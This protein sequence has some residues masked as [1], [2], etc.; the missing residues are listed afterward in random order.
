MGRSATAAIAVVAVVIFGV[1]I[2]AVTRGTAH[3]PNNSTT[4]SPS[5]S[6]SASPTTSTGASASPAAAKATV[7]YD[8][9]TF[10]PTQ[11]TVTSG[12]AITF[13][14]KSSREVDVDS[15]PHPVHTSDTELNVG[16]IAPGQSK[17]VTVTKKGNFGIHN[18]L[19]PNQTARVTVQ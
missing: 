18:H 1:L 10:T 16:P 4:P 13:I 11:N 9:S 5:P 3:S 7:S 8:G 17:T 12:G 14:N 15:D 19:N 2:F 6:A